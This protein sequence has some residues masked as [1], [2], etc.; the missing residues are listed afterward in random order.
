MT[1]TERRITSQAAERNGNI[2]TAKADRAD[3][4]RIRTVDSIQ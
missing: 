4:L 3:R 2:G 1:Q